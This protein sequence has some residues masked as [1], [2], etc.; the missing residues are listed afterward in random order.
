MSKKGF[1]LAYLDD[2]IVIDDPFTNWMFFFF[3]LGMFLGG[4]FLV[5]SVIFGWTTTE[6][7]EDKIAVVFVGLVLFLFYPAVLL[8]SGS[9]KNQEKNRFSMF[10]T[11][12][13][14]CPPLMS[15]YF[16]YKR[17]RF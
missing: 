4:I 1:K 17:S 3:Q 6:T 8:M 9:W 15:L 16:A 2:G 12:L 11:V 10:L 13:C 5:L 7:L 14:F